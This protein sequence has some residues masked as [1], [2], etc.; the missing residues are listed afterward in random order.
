[1]FI[2]NRKISPNNKPFIVAEISANHNNNI[3]RA[4]K[5]IDEAK[6]AGA[7]AVK[8]QTYTA[9][10]ITL[11]S[12]N[13]DFQ[14][15]D[16][17][18]LWDG[19]YLYDLY[20]KGSTPWE[21]HKKIFETSKKKKIICFSSP[22]D[23]SAVKFL[24]RFNPPAYKIASF[25]NNHIPM[26]KSIIKTKKPMIISLGVTRLKEILDLNKFLKM[27]KVKN[28]AFLKC[29]SSYP[30]KVED[31]NLKTII[32]LKKRLKIEIGLSD[33]TPGIGASVAAVAYG[34]S[35][36]EKHFTLNKNDGGLDDSFSI[37]PDDLYNLVNETRRAWSSLGKKFYGILKSE[38]GSMIFKRS[39]Y[40]TKFIKKGE[41]FTKKNI[42]VIRP[43][44]GVAPKYYEKIIG[45][46]SLTNIQ[47]ASP[48]KYK[49]FR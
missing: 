44:K 38:K 4:L 6:R 7:D 14:I 12:K 22:F 2:L 18:S 24:K 29:T 32:D 37:D 31:S 19:K 30:A 43:N 26:I 35:I 28:Y 5:L 15:R 16:K 3:D 10:T 17:K 40:S 49:H 9:D 39:I 45:K 23:E 46:K 1:M 42:R 36:I 13:K 48:I 34:A 41:F 8:I 47:P 25:E 21:W 11:N 33:H 27:Q 20:K